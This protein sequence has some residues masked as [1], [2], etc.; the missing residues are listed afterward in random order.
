[1]P[2]EREKGVEKEERV[3][4]DFRGLLSSNRPKAQ[5]SRREER[6]Y[7][8][9]PKSPILKGLCDKRNR[10]RKREKGTEKG[11]ISQ[12]L[13]AEC[14]K[15]E[16][17]GRSLKEGRRRRK[18]KSRFHFSGGRRRGGDHCEKR[19]FLSLGGAGHSELQ[20]RKKTQA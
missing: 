19:I 7:G 16:A 10:E 9:D 1:M 13:F 17:F 14:F 15:N 8:R 5:K 3:L 4:I 18:E 12:N 11:R 6:N 2:G 20:K